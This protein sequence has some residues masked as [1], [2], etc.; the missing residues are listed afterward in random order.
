MASDTRFWTART[1]AQIGERMV[2]EARRLDSQQA[3]YRERLHHYLR[4]YGNRNLADYVGRNWAVG[5]P[6]RRIVSDP[7]R[8][9]SLNIVRNMVDA[10]ASKLSKGR[11]SPEHVT[12]DADF[13]M[14][15][16]A[17]MRN[18]LV[19]GHFY[20]GK[21]WQLRDRVIK[22]CALIGT[23]VYHTFARWGKVQY[24]YV[25]PGELLIDNAQAML[26]YPR[27]ICRQ[28]PFDKLVL[29][30]LFPNSRKA[31]EDAE[32][33][34]SPW[35][36]NTTGDT[37]QVMVYQGYHL[38][39]GPDAGDGMIVA[40][41]Q[42]E[43]LSAEPLLV[44]R[45]PFTFMRWS[46]EPI[47]FYGTGLAEMLSGIQL[48]I[49]ELLRTI[50]ENIY[51]GGNLKVFIEKGSGV[52]E[53]EIH[54]GLRGMICTYSGTKP[55]FQVND[56]VSPQILSHLEDQ[57]RRAYEITGISQLSAQG[58]IPQGL[59]GSG[60][61]QLVYRNTESERFIPVQRADED[62]IL[63][64]AQQSLDVDRELLKKDPKLRVMFPGKSWLEEIGV[65]EA[66]EDVGP[67][68]MKC[69]P[70][71][72]MPHDIAGRVE[73]ADIFEQKGWID[74]ED[75]KELAEIPDI[76]SAMQFALAPRRLIDMEI[77]R[78]LE[79]GETPAPSPRMNLQLAVSRGAR[80]WQLA[81]LRKYPQER[82]DNL[83]AWIGKAID[84]MN[85]A[86]PPTPPTPSPDAGGAASL[87]AGPIPASP[88][89]GAANA[90]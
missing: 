84:L 78:I 71:S 38:P 63:D 15:T 46:Q 21:L 10:A 75:A 59:A 80:A 29:C 11:P 73:L 86:A 49:N 13:S 42:G 1:K 70:A 69:L 6:V 52:T 26:D 82:L 8:R 88:L 81:R 41:I 47:G 68:D 3:P 58:Q 60:R 89:N 72:Q 5:Q 30:E 27:V 43:T 25:F 66:L 54:N 53:A 17:R 55:I 9:L 64:L 31:I 67:I 22:T 65:K 57:I 48:E 2:A 87:P 74:S 77:E 45:H 61:A 39:S 18:K 12:T 35:G 62:A 85:S 37:D 34:K 14:L 4:L 28:R 7:T 56:V 19:Q 33:A 76:D 90:S 44:E 83:D 40:A 36:R 51:R 24:E 32:S 79:H 16:A 23:G 20:E 50:Q